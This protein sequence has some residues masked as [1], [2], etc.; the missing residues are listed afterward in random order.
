MWNIPTIPISFALLRYFNNSPIFSLLA[1]VIIEFYEWKTFS[2]FVCVL[3]DWE[4]MRRPRE[5]RKRRKWFPPWST[6]EW[7]ET[8]SQQN[9]RMS[10]Q[11]QPKIGRKSFSNDCLKRFMCIT[12]NSNDKFILGWTFGWFW[13]NKFLKNFWGFIT[14]SS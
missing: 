11:T 4:W 8:M 3:P 1:C 5:E 12:W 13:V 7:C 14:I 9:S 2:I 6:N 10:W